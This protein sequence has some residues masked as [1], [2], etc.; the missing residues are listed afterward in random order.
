MSPRL[1]VSTACDARHVST[2]PPAPPVLFFFL[3]PRSPIEPVF[4]DWLVQQVTQQAEDTPAAGACLDRSDHAAQVRRGGDDGRTY[5][6]AANGNTSML[7]TGWKQVGRA[8]EGRE[9]KWG[10]RGATSRCP[11]SACGWRALTLIQTLSWRPKP[12]LPLGGPANE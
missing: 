4:Q 6:S 9:G 7:L 1:L 10:E 3:P 2:S 12:H 5:W 8:G 11:F